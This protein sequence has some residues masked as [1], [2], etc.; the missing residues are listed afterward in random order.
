MKTRRTSAVAA[1][2][3]SGSFLFTTIGCTGEEGAEIE[4]A[5]GAFTGNCQWVQARGDGDGDGIDDAYEDCVLNEHAPVLRFAGQESRLPS[6]VDW[7]L[8]QTTLRFHHNNCGD[9]EV[10]PRNVTQQHLTGFWHNKK[11]GFFSGCG[12]KNDPVQITSDAIDQDHHFFLELLDHGARNGNG[13]A[14]D[15]VVYGHVYPGV[16]GGVNV[17]Y[18][19]FYPYSDAF[20]TDNH[21]GDW[22]SIQVQR[23]ANGD[24][25]RVMMA[26]HGH[27]IYYAP[28]EVTWSSGRHPVVWVA[29][30]THAS[31]GNERKC[32]DEERHWYGDFIDSCDAFS[33]R[34]WYTWPGGR[35]A[36]P[37]YQGPGI[38]NLGEKT[39]PLNGQVFILGKNVGWGEKGSL[40][41]GPT[42]PTVGGMWDLD[43]RF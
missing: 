33:G 7:Y 26:A 12:H 3:L 23:N 11:K 34:D 39:R 9:C 38:L 43:R 18:W 40:H 17:Q 1:L 42:G 4:T 20:T 22:E 21:E 19:F 36:N 31:Y 16:F 30:G 5:A 24:V 41:S 27:P 25:V 10:V 32:D 2:L 6:S 37:G 15:W 13:D 8:R 28:G 29:D 14:S 35:G